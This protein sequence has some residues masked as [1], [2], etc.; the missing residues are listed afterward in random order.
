MRCIVQCEF[1]YVNKTQYIVPSAEHLAHVVLLDRLGRIH[2]ERLGE[3][4][5]RAPL[6]RRS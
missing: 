3:F 2:P 6:R 4:A 5:D 1:T